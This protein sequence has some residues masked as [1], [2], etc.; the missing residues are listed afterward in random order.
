MTNLAGVKNADETILEE[1]YLSGIEAVKI[2]R[3]NGEV[4]YSY[5][6][7]IGNWVLTR[8]WYYWSASVENKEHGLVLGDA[9]SLYN[10][11]NPINDEVLGV[12]IRAGGDAGCSEPNGYV[13][14]PVYN[15]ELYAQLESL[16]YKKEYCDFVKEYHFS[17]TVGE[18]AALCNDGKIDAKRYVSTYHIDS[19]IGLNEFAKY[20]NDINSK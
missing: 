16:G 14:Q 20:I 9:I 1:L 19:Q 15:D 5:V 4:P 7:K 3:N 12:V 13:A 18:M 2:G 17:I 6:G 11:K 10:K 8:R